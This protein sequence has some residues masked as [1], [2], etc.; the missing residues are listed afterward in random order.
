MLKKIP[1]DELAVGMCLVDSG[2]SFIDHPYLY[3]GNTVVRSQ[4]HIEKLRAQ[5]YLEFFI[6]TERGFVARFREQAR[7][8]AREHGRLMKERPDASPERNA[9]PVTPL[10]A[11][12]AVARRLYVQALDY[13]RGALKSASGGELP[14]C[15][16]A[17][18]RVFAFIGSLDRNP[19][20]LPS[21]SRIRRRDP[22]ELTHG[23]NVAV[24]SLLFG[25]HLGLGVVDLQH[26]GAAALLHDLGKV[27][28]PRDIRSKRGR[29]APGEFEA[30]K[31]H[32]LLGCQLLKQDRGLL[33]AALKAVLDHHEKFDGSGYPRGVS[34]D[35]INPLARIITLADIYDALTSE[36]GYGRPLMPNQAMSVI[37]EM[38]ASTFHPE[39]AERFI[40]CLGLYPV[41]AFV[42]LSDGSY[43][44]VV[45]QNPKKPL[46]PKVRVILDQRMRH[47]KPFT[48]DL[49]QDPG[50]CAGLSIN[51]CLDHREFAMDINYHL[52]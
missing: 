16:Q 24:I 31:R 52:A 38:R 51:E 4:K 15:E 5:G 7:E 47:L 2:L 30:V 13:A 45:D 1:I 3:T 37:Y 42:R 29:L 14:N 32:P 49:D 43:G 27:R 41:G 35:E 26:L 6:D 17:L 10:E 11:E 20:A 23:V 36:R 12:I 28:L 9:K 50:D 21:M 33:A 19:H 48:V 39:Y 8:Q 40:Q 25:R 46:T 34:G 22:Y 18:E 44:V